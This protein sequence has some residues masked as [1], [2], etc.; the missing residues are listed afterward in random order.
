MRARQPGGRAQAIFP[1]VPVGSGSTNSVPSESGPPD[2]APKKL[3][4]QLFWLLPSL[5]SLPQVL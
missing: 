5:A 2:F 3:V 4:R 1:D